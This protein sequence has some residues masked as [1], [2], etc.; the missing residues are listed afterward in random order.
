MKSMVKQRFILATPRALVI[1]VRPRFGSRGNQI[2]A[3]VKVLYTLAQV[4]RR[5]YIL[6]TLILKKGKKVL[7]VQYSNCENS[8]DSKTDMSDF[9]G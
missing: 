9:I 3:V 2:S 8:F 1:I 4:R 7:Y 5:L 6:I